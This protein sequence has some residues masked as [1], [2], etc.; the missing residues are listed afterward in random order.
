LRSQIQLPS[1]LASIVAFWGSAACG[2][3]AHIPP[4]PV[5]PI[6]RPAQ[7]ASAALVVR[8]LAPTLYVQ[9][10]EWF[11]LS[12]VVAVV[13]PTRPIIA[14]HLLWRDDAYGAW[15]PFTRPTDQEIVWVE[16]DGATG[17]PSSLYT[18]WHGRVLHTDWRGRGPPAIDVQW[19]K[20]G[21]LPHEVNES[22]LPAMQTL[23]LFYAFTWLGVPDFL[24]G[25]LVRKGPLCFCHG[26]GRYREFTRVTPLAER[27]DAI[28][29]DERPDAV[30]REVFG[31][32]YS[33]KDLW[34][35][36]QRPETPRRDGRAVSDP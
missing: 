14:Y 33:E 12:R 5:S 24:L 35:P 13:H 1:I 19:G 34:P 21:S 17:E 6:L 26:Y 10:D 7:A 27:L 32:N 8:R 11:P 20:H 16:F 36:E 25:R 2:P 31:R 28:V 4:R 18:Y 29:V 30:L 23:N 22:D 15:L 3:H 9:R